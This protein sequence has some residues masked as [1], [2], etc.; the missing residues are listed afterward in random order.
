MALQ[1]IVFQKIGLQKI[2]NDLLYELIGRDVF[3]TCSSA[4]R[5]CEN[6]K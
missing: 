5:L 3:L 1:I 4:S 2:M 6:E